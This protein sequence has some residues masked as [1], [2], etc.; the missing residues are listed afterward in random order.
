MPLNGNMSVYLLRVSHRLM[1]ERKVEN[2]SPCFGLWTVRM[3]R[4]IKDPLPFL[5]GISVEDLVAMKNYEDR[6]PQLV[7][8][9]LKPSVY[10]TIAEPAL[11]ENKQRLIPKKPH[12]RTNETRWHPLPSHNPLISQSKYFSLFSNPDSCKNSSIIIIFNHYL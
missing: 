2:A 4:S 9:W 5:L 8:S 6:L 1:A 11:P 7:I 12:G 10:K 3:N